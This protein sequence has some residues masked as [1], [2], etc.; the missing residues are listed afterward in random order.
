[1]REERAIAGV[2]D[3]MEFTKLKGYMSGVDIN[4]KDQ[5]E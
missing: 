3:D 4:V 2:D 5:V 1:M